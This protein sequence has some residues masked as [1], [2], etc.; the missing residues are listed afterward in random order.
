MS[1]ASLTPMAFGRCYVLQLSL[2]DVLC[3]AFV[4]RSSDSVTY[5]L[6]A[7]SQS[8]TFMARFVLN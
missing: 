3:F 5:Y 1:T 4:R 7:S 8:S 6:A 2:D